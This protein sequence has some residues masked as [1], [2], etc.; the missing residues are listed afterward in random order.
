MRRLHH[1]YIRPVQCIPLARVEAEGLAVW[2]ADNR[3]PTV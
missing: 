3:A 1:E 2:L